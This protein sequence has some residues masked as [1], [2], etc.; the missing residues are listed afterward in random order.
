MAKKTGPTYREILT[1]IN[2]G[3]FAKVYILHGE[4]P[5]YID[6]LVDALESK[7]VDEDD[8]DFNQSVF[9]GADAKMEVVVAAAQEF[10]VMAQNRLVLL[11]EAQSMSQAKNALDHLAAYISKPTAST[12]LVISYKGGTL[13]ATS[14][15]MK[16]AKA[17]DAV[18]FESPKVRDY[19]LSTPIKEYCQQKRISIDEK[20]VQMLADYIGA[21]L[22]T[23][24]ASIDKLIIAGGKDKTRI[25]ADDVERNIGVSKEFNPFELTSAIAAKDYPKAMR[26]VDYFENN[27]KA[28]PIPVIAIQLFNYFSRMLLAHMSA[29]KTDSGLMSQLKM[30]QYQLREMRNGMRNYSPLSSLKAIHLIREADCKSKGIGSMAK[31]S[32][33]LKELVFNLFT[34]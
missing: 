19:Q 32:E 28:G 20:A 16:A 29:D 27:P 25:T 31:E 23:L 13:A 34:C 6:V 33:L 17:A 18:I 30:S 8:R 5:Y 4:E 12:V 1:D 14:K 10:P 7:V 21:E 9:Y 11:K 3:K 22:S 24:F 26:I 2:Q 15:L